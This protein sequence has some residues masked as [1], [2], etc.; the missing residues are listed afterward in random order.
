[1]TGGMSRPKY[2]TFEGRNRCNAWPH[3]FPTSPA[4]RIPPDTRLKGLEPTPT[5]P[6]MRN[7]SRRPAQRSSTSP[8]RCR[9][10]KNPA[11][12]SRQQS[13]L[14]PPSPNRRPGARSAGHGSN[15]PTAGTQDRS[16]PMRLLSASIASLSRARMDVR[17]RCF[18]E[19]QLR[20]NL[21]Y[22]RSGC[23]MKLTHA[24]NLSLVLVVVGWLL[25]AYG[26]LAN[27]GDPDPRIPSPVIERERHESA[28]ILCVGIISLLSSIWLSGY[29][30][31]LAKRR[32]SLALV[33]CLAPFIA[34]YA[35]T[36]G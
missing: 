15:H 24:A 22:S 28:A 25:A 29:S 17:Q 16:R 2:D 32:A 35:Y 18:R 31:T 6:R 27:F 36:F 20:L 11:P 14:F 4:S 9:R 12:E 30:F 7:C 8:G 1:M 5:E 26:V 19:A 10:V 34:L 13:G 21:L 33:A 23:P 3:R